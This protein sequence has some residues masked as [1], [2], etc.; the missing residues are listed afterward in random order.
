MAQFKWSEDSAKIGLKHQ[1]RTRG[2]NE[3]KVTQE[4][5]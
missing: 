5:V 4:K 2:L 3:D 1:S